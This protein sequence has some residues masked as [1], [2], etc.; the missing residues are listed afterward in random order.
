MTL[1]LLLPISVVDQKQVI[2]HDDLSRGIA[3]IQ[4]ILRRIKQGNSDG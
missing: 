1:D 2:H 3:F 4:L